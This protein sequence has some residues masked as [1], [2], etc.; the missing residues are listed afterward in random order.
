[1]ILRDYQQRCHDAVLK[2]WQTHRATLVVAATGTGKTIIFAHLIKST[3]PKRALVLAERKELIHQAVEKISAATGLPCEVEM[4]DQSVHTNLFH[5]TPVVVATIQTLRSGKDVKRL[6]RFQPEDFGVVIIDEA[7]HS[8]AE[9]YLATIDFF[10]RNPDL[11]ICGFTATPD[12]ADQK[13]LGQIYGS[14]AFKYDILDAVADGWLVDVTQQYCRVTSLDFSHIHTLAGDLAQNELAA[15]MES[16]KNIHGVCQPCLE[17][18]FGLQPNTL[19][20]VAPPL[21]GE[22]LSAAMRDQPSLPRRSIMFTASVLQAEMCCNIFNRVMPNIAEWVCGATQAELRKATLARFRS[23]HTAIV[24]NC[25]VLTEGFDD[26]GVH[27]IFMARPT[28]SRSLYTQ[29]CGRSTRP[30]PG[31]VEGIPAVSDRLKAIEASDKKYCRIVDFVGNS[32]RHKLVTALDV[33][34]GKSSERAVER[35]LSFAVKD[36][37]PFRVC[38]RLTNTEAEIAE[39]KRKA[40]IA[41]AKEEEA[42]KHKLYARSQFTQ[43]KVNPFGRGE[44]APSQRWLSRGGRALSEKQRRVLLKRG[45]NP[46]RLTFGQAKAVIGKI[47]QIERWKTSNQRTHERTNDSRGIPARAGPPDLSGHKV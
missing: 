38:R 17:V 34:G 37:K 23:G 31:V 19:S 7:H 22:F 46:D 12:R 27:V 21:W 28:K 16:E 43:Q 26:P 40:A 42:R 9:S 20:G 13:A 15:V 3:Q 29:M 47:A 10:K 8:A 4:A 24:M 41:R 18:M 32:G 36:G 39:E 44:P 1:V 25:G 14:V 45:L 35:A 30:L 33:L 11:R 2:E 6:H 5:R